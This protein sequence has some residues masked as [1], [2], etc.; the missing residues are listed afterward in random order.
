M[1]QRRHD[2]LEDACRRLIAA[3]MVPD[4]A[5]QPTHIQVHLSL[6]QLRDLPG[7]PQAERAWA[8]ARAREPGWL[9]GPEAAAAA[10]DAMVVPVVTGNLDPAALERFAGAVAARPLSAAGQ[11]RLRRAL[12]GLAAD[13]LSGPAGLAAWLRTGPLQPAELTSPSLPL[14][15]GAATETI[16]AHLRRA[17][18]TRN[19]GCAFPGCDT[20]ASAC[21]IHHIVPRAAGGLTALGNLLPLCLFHHLIAIHRWGWQLT[22]NPD[23]TTTATS[24]DGSRILHSHSPPARA[25]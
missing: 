22:L 3:G 18:T 14:D 23:A 5:G 20:P 12:I 9:T 25:A 6:A 16:P 8:A 1:A 11:R 2:A 24:P 21:Q 10:C 7:A 15:I 19:P 4:R 17:V 13:A